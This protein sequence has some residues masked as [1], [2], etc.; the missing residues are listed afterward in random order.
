MRLPRRMEL[1]C[2]K[3]V[4]ER[5]LSTLRKDVKEETYKLSAVNRNAHQK[6]NHRGDNQ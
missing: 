1:Q 2:Q 3:E 6:N 5:R 4:V